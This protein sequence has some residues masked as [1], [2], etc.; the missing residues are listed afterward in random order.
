MTPQLSIAT[1][2]YEHSVVVETPENPTLAWLDELEEDELYE[3]RNCPSP[4]D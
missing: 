3:S 4:S 1:A 2:V